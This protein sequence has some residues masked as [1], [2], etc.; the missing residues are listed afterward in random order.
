MDTPEGLRFMR[1]LRSSFV[2]VSCVLLPSLLL[3][4]PPEKHDALTGPQIEQIREAGIFPDQRVKLYTSFIDERADRI[5]GFATRTQSAA[6]D[7]R[8]DSELQDFTSLM[9]ELASNLDTYSERKADIRKSLKPL[10]EATQRWMAMLHSMPDDQG[11]DLSLKEAIESGGDLTDQAR[12]MLA[13]QTKYF[14]EHKDQRGQDRYEP[15]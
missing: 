15:Q 7:H 13:D 8:L 14:E 4:Q 11:Y 2:A 1:A 5:K 12:Q 6:R 9:D 10:T 3:A